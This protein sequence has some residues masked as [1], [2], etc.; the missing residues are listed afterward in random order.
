MA[1]SDVDDQ[2]FTHE[3][4]LASFQRTTKK[5]A[6]GAGGR[7]AKPLNWPHKSI[8]PADL[9]RAGFFFNPTP[10]SPDNV[11]C[12]LCRK[13]MDG[14]EA[15]DDP[16]VEHLKHSPACGWAV[17]AAVEAEYD[18]YVALDPSDPDIIEA[19]KATFAGRWPHD[20]K[21]G[22]KCKTKQLVDAGWKYTPTPDSDD[23]AT[24][25]YCQL[26]LDGW[27]RNDKPLDEHYNRSPD[28]AFFVLVNQSQSTTKKS[29]RTK[30]ARA[31]KA[32][33]LSVQSV[34]TVASDAPS[35]TELTAGP[36]DSVLTTAST[37]TQAG[38]KTKAKKATAPK[39]RKTKAKKGEPADVP[40]ATHYEADEEET[41]TK[42]RTKKRGSEAIEESLAI[43]T[44]AP[45]PKRRANRNHGS[46]GIE[47]SIVSASADVDMVDVPA[48][49]K[50]PMHKYGLPANDK[51][52]QK[53]AA[54]SKI[55]STFTSSPQAPGTDFPDDDEIERQLQADLDRQFTDEEDEVEMVEN[56]EVIRDASEDAEADT[57]AANKAAQY[58]MFN[59]APAE[60]DDEIL[61]DE[62]RALQEEMEA[63]EP[64]EPL[65]IPKK[66]RKTGTRKV[67]KQAKAKPA[68]AIESSPEDEHLNAEVAASA[69]DAIEAAASEQEKSHLE[70]DISFGSTDTVLKKEK[71][72]RGRPSKASLA[73]RN[74][75]G[76]AESSQPE[77]Q[78]VKRGRGRPSKASLASQHAEDSAE[79]SSAEPPAKRGRGRPSK[80]SLESR[81]SVELVDTRSTEAARTDA[82]LLAS[83]KSPEIFVAAAESLPEA[84]REPVGS[85]SRSSGAGR[86]GRP[87]ATPHKVISPAQ[88]ARQPAVSPSPSPQSSDAENQPPSS[89]PAASA[90]KKRVVL[91]P[92]ASTPT[93]TSPSKRNVL[94]RLQTTTPWTAVD[95]EAVLG[96]PRGNVDK[97]NVVERFLKQGKELTSPEKQ[98]T[99]EE[100]IN[101]NADEAEKLLKHECEAM[102]N[103]FENEGTRAI[104]VLEGLEVD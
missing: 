93:R 19:R 100:W 98:M 25:S 75:I 23:M 83:I 96:T 92:V 5:R 67:S 24:C 41:T 70:P 37:M 6:S 52:P 31:S 4:R 72:G 91:A 71:R 60:L 89:R 56:F 14:W 1:S 97:E 42:K 36:E 99:V 79:T 50:S 47:S 13:G 32:S 94:G 78:P 66:E 101:Y 2:Y 86:L 55:S 46:T 11:V 61:D 40:D 43:A 58:A 77:Q 35:M 65:H 63:D 85:P 29:G 44:E 103:R 87:T 95:L 17:Q 20:G 64:N 18:D 62:L 26:A 27:E 104:G 73:S 68:K 51:Q 10:E 74:S 45:A 3:G 8:P 80:K 102:V 22:W 57:K 84:T 49:Q 28:C 21:K 53:A 76:P 88:S 16:L 9:A 48:G 7:G 54:A 82:E 69:P 59:P 81:K 39:G 33:R 38:K 34:A 30:T 15:G 12:F 90:V